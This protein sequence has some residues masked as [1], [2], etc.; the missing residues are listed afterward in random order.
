MTAWTDLVSKMFKEG[1]S[2]NP[3]FKLKDAMK[4]AAKVYKKGSSSNVVAPTGN[5]TKK[6]RN[7]RRRAAK[8]CGTKRRRGSRRRR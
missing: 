1:R 8:A 5:G 2:S 3:N 6:C 7:M 4:S